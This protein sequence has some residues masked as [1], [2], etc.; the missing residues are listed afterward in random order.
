MPNDARREAGRILHLVER[1]QINRSIERRKERLDLDVLKHLKREMEGLV[2]TDARQALR[3]ATAMKGLLPFVDEEAAPAIVSQAWAEALFFLGR[4]QEALDAYRDAVRLFGDAGA[5][6][7]G[8]R[9]SVGEINSLMYL[10]RF[11]EAL[12]TLRRAERI[13]RSHDERSYLGRLYITRGSLLFHMDRYREALRYYEKGRQTLGPGLDRDET[14]V[15]LEMNEAAIHASLDDVKRAESLFTSAVQR[16]TDLGLHSLS[17]QGN[18]NLASVLFLQ[19]RYQEALAALSQ[20]TAV[21]KREDRSLAAIAEATRAEIYLRLNMSHEAALHADS[22]LR[23]FVKAGM[24]FD[25]GLARYASGIALAREGRLVEGKKRLLAARRYF[26]SRGNRVREAAIDLHLARL[27]AEEGRWEIA[28][29]RAQMAERTLRG[30]GLESRA[31]LARLARA[32]IELAAGRAGAARRLLAGVGVPTDL[33]ARFE[34][35]Y[36]SGRVDEADGRTTKALDAYRQ[37]A[38]L[39]EIVRVSLAGEEHK[40]AVEASRAQVAERA[41]ALLLSQPRRGSVRRSP[42]LDSV[43]ADTKRRRSI[44]RIDSEVFEFV[45][46]AKAR[47]LGDLLSGL[48]MPQRRTRGKERATSTRIEQATRKLSWHAAKLEQAELAMRGSPGAAP[49]LARKVALCERQITGLLRT[50]REE[51]CAH[52]GTISPLAPISLEAARRQLDENELVIEYFAAG[53]RLFAFLIDRRSARIVDLGVAVAQ[54]DRL[55]SRLSFQMET[56]RLGREA[57]SAHSTRLCETTS[58]LMKEAH[59]LLIR[60]L[61]P[62]AEGARLT[63]IPHGVLNRFPF[64]ALDDGE[65]PLGERTLV[66]CAPS[67]ATF[68][69]LRSIAPSPNRRALVGGFADEKAPEIRR[70]IAAVT[71]ALTGMKPVAR[72]ALRSDEFLRLAPSAHLIHLATHA[73]YRDDNPLFSA[74]RLADRWVHLYEIL[75]L[76]LDADLVVLSGCE[77]G[78]GRHFAG[79]EMLGLARGFLARGARRL[80]VSLWP[81]DDP[82]TA[83]LVAHFH[84]AHASGLEPAVALREASLAIRERC[85]HPYHWAPFTMLGA[86]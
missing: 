40:I 52:L 61:G 55:Q 17:A 16:A 28:R 11:A 39:A 27:F 26:A 34:K 3:L 54:V 59:A 22:A 75:N 45:E 7:D 35:M 42:S 13:L 72:P 37:A 12:E 71:R 9:A 18:L 65:K 29:K 83:R 64:Q 47:A 69:M 51:E 31:S 86:S 78:A 48:A 79:D 2:R 56:V 58:K 6:L 43:F 10:S 53:G 5:S 81:V 49:E 67:F 19:S 30:R 57:L 8:A 76:D 80:L 33:L 38:A 85:P 46:A 23:H 1:G 32:E 50:M 15:A 14:I 60:H 36:L 63:I 84:R 24:G 66:S 82:S 70:E 77:T 62:I 73:R 74:V 44:R 25:A 68:A 4:Y 20:A 41:I 21:F